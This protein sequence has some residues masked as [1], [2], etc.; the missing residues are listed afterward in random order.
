MDF[1]LID[2]QKQ[3]VDLLDELGKRMFQIGFGMTQ[4]QMN[5]IARSV[6]RQKFEI[7]NN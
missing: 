4:A 5:V 6:Y 3:I 7:R 1:K 2:E